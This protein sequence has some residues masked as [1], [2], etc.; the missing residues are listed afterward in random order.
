MPKSQLIIIRNVMKFDM[1]SLPLL[2]FKLNLWLGFELEITSKVAYSQ[3]AFH[4]DSNLQKKVSNHYS[5]LYSHKEKILRIV[6]GTT[7]RRLE[8]T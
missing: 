1:Q 2:Q 3:K 6:F 5:E 8:L 4:F 7:F